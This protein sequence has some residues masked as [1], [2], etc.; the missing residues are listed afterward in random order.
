[1]LLLAGRLLLLVLQYGEDPANKEFGEEF[2]KAMTYFT[3]H[4]LE[5]GDLT[6]QVGHSHILGLLGP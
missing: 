2:C 4:S 6:L 5:G 3:R 1:M